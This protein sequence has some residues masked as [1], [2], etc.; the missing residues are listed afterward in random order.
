MPV[1]DGA[2][3]A[4]HDSGWVS[5]APPSAR[6]RERLRA[7]RR[8]RGSTLACA[9]SWALLGSAGCARDGSSSSSASAPAAQEPQLDLI[10]DAPWPAAYSADPL[11]V[12]AAAGDDLDRARLGRRESAGALLDAVRSGGSLGRVALSAFAYA[13][14]RRSERHALCELCARAEPSSR[15]LLVQTLLDTVLNAPPAEEARDPDA[16]ARCARTL[17]A[18]EQNSD[19]TPTERDGARVLLGR[20]RAP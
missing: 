17:E 6:R 3:G 11:W 2:L 8:A 19:A 5:P 20:L 9:L 13:S 15:A 10:G 14:D 7:P 16:D 12:R 18:I 4:V 1:D